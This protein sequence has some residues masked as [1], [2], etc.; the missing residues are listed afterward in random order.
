MEHRKTM[1]KQKYRFYV[2]LAFTYNNP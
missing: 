1:C 2:K